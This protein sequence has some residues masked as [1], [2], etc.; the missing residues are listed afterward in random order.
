MKKILLAFLIPAI[1]WAG[2]VQL[3]QITN[4][5]ALHGLP[6]G[7]N[8]YSVS[9]YAGLQA[10]TNMW[11]GDHA[12]EQDNGQEWL[13][14]CT[15]PVPNG[16]PALGSGSWVSIQT[17]GS[18]TPTMTP[19]STKTVTPS[20]TPSSTQ[21]AAPSWTPGSG[22]QFTFTPTST[23]TCAP[24]MTPGCGNQALA[25]A[26]PFPIQGTQTPG[27]TLTG[28]TTYN[29][30]GFSQLTEANI[31]LNKV[32]MTPGIYNNLTIYT[33]IG[34]Y[35]GRG[36]IYTDNSGTPQSLVSGSLDVPITIGWNSVPIQPTFLS[37]TYWDGFQPQST[38]N[39][40]NGASGNF[41]R[42]PAP[43]NN[44]LPQTI[45]TG[46]ANSGDQFV[47]YI[48]SCTPSSKTV[49]N[50]GDSIANGSFASWSG[51]GGYTY[52]LAQYLN[53]KYPT[54]TAVNNGHGGFTSAQIAQVLP[55]DILSSGV[56]QSAVI[57]PIGTNDLIALGGY[58]TPGGAT[59]AQGLAASFAYKEVLENQ[60]CQVVMSSLSSGGK[61][62]LLTIYDMPNS[63]YFLPGQWTNGSYETIRGYYNQRIIEVGQ[64]LGIPVFNTDSVL[65]PSNSLLY[66]SDSL[67]LSDYGESAVCAGLENPTFKLSEEIRQ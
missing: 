58:P 11:C 30:G 14:K 47:I 4:S 57:G 37:G 43:W 1:S 15:T 18:P 49:I 66:V 51:L 17:F 59:N 22:N 62:V 10:V 33:T 32:V 65:N 35:L 64:D 55:A 63:V 26:T 40:Y 27:P 39:F 8:S 21:T 48:N 12:Y 44:G 25:T 61:A 13:Y 3:N 41:Y 2:E 19:T 54:Y 38:Q 6:A 52:L 9:N 46:T 53:W 56:Y 67:H 28:Q 42:S 20:Y 5:N 16:T 45:A 31:E 7:A 50:C 23:Q 60:I 29:T 36:G 34:G 24:S